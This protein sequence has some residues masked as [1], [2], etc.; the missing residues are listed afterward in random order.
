MAL[1]D[2]ARSPVKNDPD[3]ENVLVVLCGASCMASPLINIALPPKLTTL[4]APTIAG[5][6]LTLYIVFPPIV[7][8]QMPIRA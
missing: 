3:P 4:K 1:F 6:V 7:C 5:K 2:L 8:R